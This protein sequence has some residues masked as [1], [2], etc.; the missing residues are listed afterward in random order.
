MTTMS[1]TDA[2]TG[3]DVEADTDELARR[4]ERAALR[5]ANAD[6][7]TRNEAL[8]S[9]ADAIRDREAEILEANA[10]DVEE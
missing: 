3:S 2:D 7:A 1:E 5:L 6:E 8:R 10:V 9:I 4:A